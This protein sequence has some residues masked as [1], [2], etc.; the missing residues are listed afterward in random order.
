M[1]KGEVN[2][3]SI[4]RSIGKTPFE[5][6]NEKGGLSKGASHRIHHEKRYRISINKGASESGREGASKGKIL[7]D[8]EAG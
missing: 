1:G 4:T 2:Q 3:P 6:G 7:S 5:K 8:K